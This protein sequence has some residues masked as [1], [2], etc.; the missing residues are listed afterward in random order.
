VRFKLLDGVLPWR[1]RPHQA[2]VVGEHDA[3]DVID[4]VIEDCQDLFAVHPVKR[5]AHGDQP[6]APEIAWEICRAALCPGHI[7]DVG[8]LGLSGGF[9]EHLGLRVHADSFSDVPGKRECQ[10]AGAAT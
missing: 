6:E 1:G 7:R 3:A 8:C 4:H 9:G 10:L 5:A 2:T